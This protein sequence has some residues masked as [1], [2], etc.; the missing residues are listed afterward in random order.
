MNINTKEYWD[1][2]FATG[3]WEKN[4]GKLQTKI[5]ALSQIPLLNIDKNFEGTILDFGCGLGDAIP[6]YRMA[7]PKA[8]LIGMDIS[9]A[10]IE[11]C[12]NRF[13]NM[14]SFISGSHND[15]P[16]VDV[17]I[18][19]NVFEHLSND[20]LI[21]KILLTKCNSLYI[22]TPFN[23]FIIAGNE[24][25]NSYQPN[26]YRELSIPYDFKIFKVKGHSETFFELVVNIYIKNLIRIIFKK[27]IVRPRLQIMYFFSRNIM[28]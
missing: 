28:K 23:E 20:R 3:D 12:K 2:R 13:G 15:V 18:S 25:V 5:F 16:E 9:D 19:S 8:K 14:A 21:V 17:I 1:K 6:L 11:E 26:Y 27:K 7:F 22:F 10:A 4:K 24:H